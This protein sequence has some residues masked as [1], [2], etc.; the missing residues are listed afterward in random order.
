[1]STLGQLLRRRDV[2]AA[3]VERHL[4]G[5][6]PAERL[7][8]TLALAARTQA[9]L[10]TLAEGHRALTLAQ[11]TPRK[12][13]LEPVTHE[14]RNSLPAFRYFAKVF[15]RPDDGSAERWGYNRNPPLVYQTVGPGY[16]VAVQH[17]PLEVLVDYTLTPPRRPEAWP[18]ITHKYDKLSRFVFFGTQDVL[19]GVS[20]HVSIGRARR[21]GR[22]MDNWF[23]LCRT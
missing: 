16:F 9:R 4:D 15:C 10:F 12:K 17:G 5:L 1:M 21:Q 20:E 22:W 6:E 23:V 3:A 13:P 7:K 11:L 14:G 2:T 19:R 18:P 8:Q